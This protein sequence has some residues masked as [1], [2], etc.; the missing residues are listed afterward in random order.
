[1]RE[2]GHYIF[3]SPPVSPHMLATPTDFLQSD[4][5]LRLEETD[6]ECGSAVDVFVLKDFPVPCQ[7]PRLIRVVPW[8]YHLSRSNS[9]CQR[10]R[11]NVQTI[12]GVKTCL[13]T[14]YWLGHSS[15]NTCASALESERHSPQEICTSIRAFSS[16][17]G[18]I[19]KATR[20]N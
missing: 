17:S 16:F 13:K 9:E 5:H 19:R 14:G 11:S 4:L 15:K 10:H 2:S 6:E 3:V 8:R 1:M 12:T 7:L 18:P 20:Q